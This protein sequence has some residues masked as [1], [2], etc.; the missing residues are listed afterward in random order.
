MSV[1]VQTLMAFAD[2]ALPPEEAARVAALVAA[3]PDLA[4]QVAELRAGRAAVRDAF[5]AVLREPVPDRLIRAATGAS[6]AGAAS[7]PPTRPV[8]SN[9][10]PPLRRAP[11]RWRRPAVAAAASLLLGLGG[12]WALAPGGDPAGPGRLGRALE[13]ALEGAPAGASA[14]VTLLASHRLED[15][16]VCRSFAAPQGEGRLLGLACR[17]QAGGWRLRAAVAQQGGDALRPAGGKDPLL[18]EMLERLGAA[19]AMAPAEERAA[20][21]RGWR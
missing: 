7:I 9:D 8:A 14:G 17:E 6:P 18:A 21:A 5:A 1:P 3:D 19:P 20:I 4:R 15:G 2:G 12:G 10:N 13:A 16:G 11:P